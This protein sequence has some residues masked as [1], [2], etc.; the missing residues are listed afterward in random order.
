ML[1]PM[2]KSDQPV[3]YDEQFKKMMCRG[4]SVDELCAHVAN[5]GTLI[6]LAKIWNVRYSDLAN[7]MASS[8]TLVQRMDRAL[9]ARNE[10]EIEIMIRELRAI[11]TC[12]IRDAYNVDGSLKKMTDMPANVAAALAS[13]E[14]DELFEGVGRDRE[15]IGVTKRVKFWD[16]A[17]AIELFMKKHGLLIDRHKVEIETR[18]EDLV[19]A[20]NADIVE[21]QAL[22]VEGD[23]PKLST[24]LSTSIAAIEPEIVGGIPAAGPVPGVLELPTDRE[25][26]V[27]YE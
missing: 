6:D 7:Y 8:R 22:P 4:E 11:A 25:R 21:T 18:L 9:I 24:G 1:R 3:E 2:S 12:D 17:K 19:G 5:G 15:Q 16:K 27:P 20:V 10:W 23:H 14:V 13:V 26:P